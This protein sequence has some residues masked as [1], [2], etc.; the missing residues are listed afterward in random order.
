MNEYLEKYLEQLQSILP[1]IAFKAD[2]QKKH[3]GFNYKYSPRGSSHHWLSF[4]IIHEP[5]LEYWFNI[6]A[7]K[8]LDDFELIKEILL[9]INESN[10]AFKIL[11][12]KA[13]FL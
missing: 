9:E 8:Y 2:K 11:E 1:S 12:K 4:G 6:G 5:Q 10:E 7:V 3:T 13:N